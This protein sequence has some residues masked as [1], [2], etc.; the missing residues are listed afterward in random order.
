MMS[1]LLST[2]L[3][4]TLSLSA[5]GSSES[6]VK[7]YIK[8]Y[9]VKSP[10]VKVE[11]VDIIDKQQLDKPKGWDVY[12]VNIHANIKKSATVTDK[13]TV[14]ET[15]F[16]KDGFVAISLIDMKTGKDF[17]MELKPELNPK[18]YDD[19]H[20]FAGNKDAK[21]KIVVFSDPQCP[22]CQEKVPEIYKAVKA[23]PKTFA[24]YYYHFPLL[25][26]HPVSDII[27][28]VMVI[29]QE[30]GNFD[31]VIDM[32][33]LKVDIH[34]V[35]ATKVLDKINKEYGLKITEK[36]IDAKNIADELK[37]D[38]TMATKSMVA[39]TPTVYVDGKWD[40]TRNGYKKL[41]TKKN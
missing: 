22:F 39:G 16:V 9:I 11:S 10:R 26:I 18:I 6:E 29:E 31:K 36:D 2:T 17:K 4:A 28:R 25:R 15:I 33:N 32:Y 7:D 21:H 35:N 19:K 30:K 40:K 12:F 38:Q 20:L 3:I 34:E 1:R 8:K 27:T 37:H 14:P 5:A 13:A 23:N 24:M 41:I